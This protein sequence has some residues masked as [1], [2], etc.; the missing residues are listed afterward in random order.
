M[1]KDARKKADTFNA[2]AATGKALQAQ[3]FA[4]AA[5]NDFAS[6]QRIVMDNPGAPQWRNAEGL[7]GLMVAAQEGAKE[8]AWVLSRADGADV[9]AQNGNGSTA[10]MYAAFSGKA[11]VAEVLL[12]AG[13]NVNHTNNN[14]HTA[15]MSAAAH[16]YRNTLTLLLQSGADPT[17]KDGDGVSAADYARDNDFPE[18]EKL[19]KDAAA[20]WAPPAPPS[21]QEAFEEA[22]KEGK[23]Y[24]NSD[25]IRALEQK[26]IKAKLV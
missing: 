26:L 14:G 1:A 5:G 22:A 15:L 11:S 16:G 2:G 23:Y 8:A 21:A 19:I 20:K 10:L 24:R 12:K 13:A 17:A 4:F 3:F 18:L 25:A 9:N 6:L 7:T